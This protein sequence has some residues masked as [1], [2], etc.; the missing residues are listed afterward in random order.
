MA[1]ELSLRADPAPLRRVR[2]GS[3]ARAL[4]SRVACDIERMPGPGSAFRRVE[5][6]KQVHLFLQLRERAGR[7]H[8]REHRK[9]AGQRRCD[10]DALDQGAQVQGADTAGQ[11]GVLRGGGGEWGEEVQAQGGD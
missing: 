11:S 4:P 9:R 2:V 7:P 6:D 5:P 1:G 3:L 8:H 10:G